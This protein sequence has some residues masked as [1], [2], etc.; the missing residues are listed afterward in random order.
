[1]TR[2]LDV[3][4]RLAGLLPD[5]LPE[6][7]MP[8]LHQWFEEA[9]QAKAVPNPGAMAL[10]TCSPDGDPSVRTVLCKSVDVAAGGLTFY[11]NYQSPKARDLEANPR[12]AVVFNW[13]HASRQV[14]LHGAVCRA[15][16]AESDAY[17]ASR[18]LLSRL[19]AWT[20]AQSEPI[21][22]RTELVHKLRE[23]MERFDVGVTDLLR[24][25]AAIE[26][27]RPPHWGGYRLAADR[28]ELWVS[29]GGR[30]HDRA[31]WFRTDGGAWTA[32]RLQ[33]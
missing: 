15:T 20:S 3:V 26:I 21:D 4:G 2:L 32:T 6:D 12:A 16:D 22:G 7:P 1:M 27:P 30:L 24:G 17:F 8:L 13:D 31:G 25:N 11:T 33:P 23:V 28:V 19:G 5:P 10:S 14:R 29:V 18:A 9:M